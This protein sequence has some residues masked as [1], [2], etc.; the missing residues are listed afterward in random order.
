MF[1]M[2]KGRFEIELK[3]PIEVATKGKMELC[4]KLAFY[5]P[6]MDSETV[7]MRLCQLVRKSSFQAIGNTKGLRSD[8]K[9]EKE[10]EYS[11]GETPIPFHKRPEM[12][13]EDVKALEKEAADI[14]ELFISS[15][16]DPEDFCMAGRMLFTRIFKSKER[17][18]LCTVVFEETETPLT[19]ELW[20]SMALADKLYCMGMYY[21]FFDISSI[22]RR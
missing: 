10:V 20:E 15:D 6:V 9:E 5:E 8:D 7:A 18:H 19:P 12:N 22:G 17:E 1:N 21:S 14:T 16:I 4:D 13:D 11:V 3:Q 2:K